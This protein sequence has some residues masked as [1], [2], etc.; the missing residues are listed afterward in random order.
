ME[1]LRLQLLSKQDWQQFFDADSCLLAVPQTS[2]AFVVSSKATSKDRREANT[3]GESPVLVEIYLGASTP[4]VLLRGK[5]AQI[6]DG[7]TLVRLEDTE[8]DK[9]EYIRGFMRGGLLNLR[10]QRRIPTEIPVDCGVEQPSFSVKTRDIN[11]EGI[12]LVTDSPLPEGSRVCMQIH[13]PNSNVMECTGVVRHTVVVEDEDIPGMGIVYEL[14][15]EQKVEMV[16]E[17]DTLQAQM[18]EGLIPTAAFSLS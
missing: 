12:F 17:V 4:L 18:A 14:S 7:S 16:A 2:E 9:L 15:P 10:K 13:W 11:E 1:R 3:D 5:I 6:M 8:R